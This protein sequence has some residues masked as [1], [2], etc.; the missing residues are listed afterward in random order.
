MKRKMMILVLLSAIAAGL[1]YFICTWSIIIDKFS[2]KPVRFK[3]R[4]HYSVMDVQ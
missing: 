2:D 4:R 1:T 3:K